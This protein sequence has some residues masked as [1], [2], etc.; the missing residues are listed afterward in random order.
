MNKTLV[1]KSKEVKRIYRD[2]NDMNR[3]LQIMTS[4]LA[5]KEQSLWKVIRRNYPDL[6][7]TE[8]SVFKSGKNLTISYDNNKPVLY[9]FYFTF[10]DNHKAGHLSF[11]IIKAFTEH[12]A[13]IIMH[14]RVKD[15]WAFC[16]SEESWF[17]DVEDG[18]IPNEVFWDED[19]LEWTKELSE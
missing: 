18:L 6:D 8:A 2:F 12:E 4:A 9:E 19:N 5:H 11:T 3:G 1:V 13:R 14:D 17:N 16:Y 7:F 10:G 15:Q